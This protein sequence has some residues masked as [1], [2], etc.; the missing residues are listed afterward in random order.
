MQLHKIKFQRKY[1]S[2]IDKTQLYNLNELLI[3]NFY[4]LSKLQLW[5][6]QFENITSMHG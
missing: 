2:K 1:C 5:F 6:I 3:R 4:L